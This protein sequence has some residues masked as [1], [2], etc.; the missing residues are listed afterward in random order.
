MVFDF[1]QY[2]QGIQ[3]NND[4]YVEAMAMLNMNIIKNCKNE[5]VMDAEGQTEF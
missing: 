1:V 2:E 5:D 4:H 3:V